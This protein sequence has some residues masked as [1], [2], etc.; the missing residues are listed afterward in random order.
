MRKIQ[1]LT[2]LSWRDVAISSEKRR[3]VNLI[4]LWEEHRESNPDGYGY[5]RFYKFYRDFEHRL[6]LIMRQHYVAGDKLFVDYSGKKIDMVD[7][8][9][10][11][12]R[13]AEIFVA[14]LG[15]SNYT[16][17]E[18]SWTQGLPD[19]IGAHVRLFRFC[20]GLPRM[21]IPDNLKS[22]ALI[23]I[24]KIARNSDPLRGGFRVQF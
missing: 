5:S 12:V 9:T 3:G 15:A 10:G 21:V 4:V 8:I 22:A 17:A 2:I 16:Y 23:L 19:W 7:H 1:T 24:C 18:A 6:A 13:T 20:S 14:V 11:E